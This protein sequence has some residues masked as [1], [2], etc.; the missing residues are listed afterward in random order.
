MFNARIEQ[1]EIPERFQAMLDDL[2]AF[3]P[4]DGRLAGSGTLLHRTVG[5]VHHSFARFGIPEK[6]WH[7]M[8]WEVSAAAQALHRRA[9]GHAGPPRAGRRRL[10]RARFS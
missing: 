10:L 2:C 8:G 3:G 7:D 1:S 5:R 9:V 6:T 4:L